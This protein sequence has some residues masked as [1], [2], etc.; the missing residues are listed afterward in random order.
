VDYC[1]A[2][3]LANTH[4]EQ[5][6]RNDELA[7]GVCFC[8]DGFKYDSDTDACLEYTCE[9]DCDACPNADHCSLCAAGKELDSAQQ[10]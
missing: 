3:K 6:G 1:L 5:L 10:A 7:F 4:F 8:E 2:C 9:T